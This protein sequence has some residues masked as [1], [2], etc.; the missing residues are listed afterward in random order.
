MNDG[1]FMT[2]TAPIPAERPAFR[3]L[4]R[5]IAIIPDGN[6]RWAQGRG[7]PKERGYEHGIMPGLTLYEEG[8]RLG[9][10]E[11]SV[12][13]YTQDNTKRPRIQVEA[14]QQAV[15]DFVALLKERN[16]AF[17]IIGDANSPLFPPEFRSHCVPPPASG[18]PKVNL[19]VNYGWKWDLETGARRMA[20]GEAKSLAEGMGSRDVS[21]IDLVIRWGG[22]RRLSGLLP[23]QAVYADFYVI[24]E[25]WPDFTMSQFYRA[26]EWYQ[27]QDVT[28]GG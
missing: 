4:P 24:D 11:V 7:W 16:A 13:A 15:L 21:R 17:Q 10:E 1:G 23:V 12:Y 6:R 9:I 5:H 26:L 25:Y 2:L 8:A 22:R 19:L 18:A 3:R 14:Y 28:L 20:D 27:E